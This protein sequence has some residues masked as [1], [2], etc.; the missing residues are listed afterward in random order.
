MVISL[1]TPNRAIEFLTTSVKSPSSYRPVAPMA[2]PTSTRQQTSQTPAELAAPPEIS[3]D[4][5]ALARERTSALAAWK[6][7]A[8]NSAQAASTSTTAAAM[9]APESGP[10]TDSSTPAKAMESAMQTRGQ[11]QS[12][13]HTALMAQANA[14]PQALLSLLRE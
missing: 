8:P 5:V 14:K 7:G 6:T 12:Q 4:A 9:V 13:A 10:L 11:I 3:K 1:V 2:A